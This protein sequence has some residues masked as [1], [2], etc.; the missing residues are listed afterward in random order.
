[1]SF[2]VKTRIVPFLAV[3]AL[4]GLSPAQ[5]Q[6]A[7]YPEKPIKLVV[8][9]APG[10]ATD[11]IA[12]IIGKRLG[13]ELG[14]TVVVENK[15]GAGG[16][17]GTASF[18]REKPDGYTLL[19]TTSSTNAINPHLYA[20]TGYDAEKDFA[21]VALVGSIPNVLEVPAKSQFETASQLLDYAKANPGKLNYG[22]AGVGS[23]QHLAA[24]QLIQSAGIDI[25]HIPY[26]GSGPA[27]AD[28]L[29][30]NL[31]LMLDTGSLAQVRAGALRALAVAS[32]TRLSVLPEV[33]TFDEVGL[34]DM[35]AAAWYGV[36][37][38][39]ATPAPVVERLNQEILKILKEPAI[40]EQ[41]EKMGVQIGEPFT[42]AQLDAFVLSEIKRF[43]SLVEMSG[44]KLE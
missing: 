2:K 24:A 32:K 43:K 13:E 17:I 3:A 22:S 4:V 29:G 21:H 11:V 23:S 25:T 20:Q 9:W 36:A 44:A 38:H 34:K 10:G 27:V 6:D 33:P 42:P 5:A 12:R 26:K 15:G 19:M 37:A 28:L 7:A 18:V 30:A 1:M 16:N 39:A 14:Q 8:P 35:Y 41:L 40:V 31:D